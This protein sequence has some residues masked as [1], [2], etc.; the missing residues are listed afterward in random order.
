MI[1]TTLEKTENPLLSDNHPS[2]QCDLEFSRCF[3]KCKWITIRKELTWYHRRTVQSQ[4]TSDCNHN[5]KLG[6]RVNFIAAHL[7]NLFQSLNN[8]ACKRRLC[9]IKQDI[10]QG[11]S[12]SA[13][14][15]AGKKI[16]PVYKWYTLGP[17]EDKIPCPGSESLAELCCT[18]S[19]FKVVF[20]AMEVVLFCFWSWLSGRHFNAATRFLGW[21]SLL[22]VCSLNLWIKTWMN[23]ERER[24]VSPARHTVCAAASVQRQGPSLLQS[25]LQEM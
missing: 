12:D 7:F 8:K 10:T 11:R 5:A 3:K 21:T 15:M 23:Y 6:N 20:P 19:Y 22:T 9:T 25:S 17:D 2:Y 16:Q 24:G 14:Q 4:P 1:C 18:G 13:G